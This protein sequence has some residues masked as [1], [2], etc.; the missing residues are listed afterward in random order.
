[1]A[2]S[3]SAWRTRHTWLANTASPT[4]QFGHGSRALNGTRS[5][6]ISMPTSR[7]GIRRSPPGRRWRGATT[8]PSSSPASPC[9]PDRSTRQKG[10]PMHKQRQFSGVIAPVL[11]PFGEDGS[12]DA[13]RFV[14]H[15][16][17]LLQE[18][19]TALAPFGTTSEGNSLGVDERIDRKSTRLNSSHLGISYAVFCLKKKNKQ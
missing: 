12:P 3:T 5:T 18:G 11:T 8:F 10:C 17:W 14:A 2:C 7:A 6:S 4:W 1:M 19:W 9:R 15:C 13:E 16:E